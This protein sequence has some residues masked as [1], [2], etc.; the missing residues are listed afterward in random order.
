MLFYRRTFH[1]SLEPP[2]VNS[3]TSHT[4]SIS[5]NNNAQFLHSTSYLSF[6]VLYT[7]KDSII[8]H[9]LQMGKLRHNKVK[10]FVPN[11]PAGQWQS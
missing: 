5:N 6:Q 2:G 10:W 8:L 1:P 3:N 11:Q 9:I 7:E 4:S